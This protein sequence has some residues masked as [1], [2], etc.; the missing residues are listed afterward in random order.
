M[1]V[2]HSR[3]R[4]QAA[5]DGL[6]HR[7][8]GIV[9]DLFIGWKRF[10]TFAHQSG[11]LTASEVEDYCSRIWKALTE[12]ARRQSQHQREANPVD[13]FLESLRSAIASGG[14]HIATRAG[15]MPDNPGARGW[16][17]RQV[18]AR[19]DQRVRWLPQGARVGRLDGDDLYL[20]IDSAYCAAQAMAADGD[21]IALGVQALIKRLHQSGRLKSFDK[22]RGKLKIRRTIEGSRLEVLHLHADVVEHSIVEKS[23]PIGPMGQ[24]ADAARR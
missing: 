18:A 3:Y 15:G 6:H 13:R 20:D 19:N 10:L 12:V 11:A 8:P 7:T 16:R 4:E 17:V 21:C 2:A 1:S 14:A 23:G 22:R 9:A 5:H 24:S